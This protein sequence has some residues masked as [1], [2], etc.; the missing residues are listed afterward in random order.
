MARPSKVPVAE[1]DPTVPINPY[2]MSKLMTEA[3]LRDVAAA[4]PINYCAP[5]LL[6][7]R[8]RRSAGAVGPV[9]RRRDPPDQDRGRGGDRQARRVSVFGTDFATPRRHRRARLHPRHRPRRRACRRARAAGRRAGARA[10]RSTAATAAAFRCCEVLDAVDRVTN[11]TIERR[12]EARRAGDPAELVADNAR[13]P[14]DAADWRPRARRPRRHRPRCARLGAQAGGAGRVR[15]RSLLFVPGDRPERFA[16]AAASGRR[17]ADPRPGGFGRAG[18]QGGGAGGGGGVSCAE[19]RTLH[20][21]R[22]RS[23][24]STPT[25]VDDDLAALPARARR[26]RA[27]QGGRRARRSRALAEPA[28][29]AADPAGRDRDARGDV[30]ARQLRD[31]RARGSPG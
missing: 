15:L 4:H 9:D 22:P 3:M 30:P 19:P 8:R 7:R 17:R 13:D 11:M 24:R 10:T 5:A 2:G 12:M 14:G 16:K 20:A 21:L 25:V 31:G 6:Q 18:A 23:T 1:G 27:A 26:A 28:A 29:G